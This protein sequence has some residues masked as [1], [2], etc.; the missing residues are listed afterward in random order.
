MLRRIDAIGRNDP[1]RGISDAGNIEDSRRRDD[2]CRWLSRIAVASPR[3]RA[4]GL[5]P[6]RPGVS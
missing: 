5:A 2:V 4:V 6:P 1:A 3:R